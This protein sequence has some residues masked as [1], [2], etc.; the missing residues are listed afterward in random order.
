MDLYEY[1]EEQG[2]SNSEYD[3]VCEGYNLGLSK[4]RDWNSIEEDGLPECD[5][6]FIAVKE[7]G[8]DLYSI[9]EFSNG[10]FWSGTVTNVTHYKYIE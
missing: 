10:I 8:T 9:C 6:K 5:V 7:D 2:Y 4:H 1:C 3:L